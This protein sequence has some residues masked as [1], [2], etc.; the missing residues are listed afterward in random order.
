MIVNIKKGH[1]VEYFKCGTLQESFNKYENGWTFKFITCPIC[2][3]SNFAKEKD[4]LLCEFC[5]DVVRFT[6][7]DG[8]MDIT[9]T[10][11]VWG[12]LGGPSEILKIKTL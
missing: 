7:P 5:L 6:H 2:K 4:D 11:T 8:E 12:I 10:N 3:G 9:I 1:S